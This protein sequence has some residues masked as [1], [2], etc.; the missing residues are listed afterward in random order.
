MSYAPFSTLHL[1]RS[2]FEF[3]NSRWRWP[4]GFTQQRSIHTFMKTTKNNNA[5]KPKTQQPKQMAR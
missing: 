3:Q 1:A 5:Y 4:T 2:H